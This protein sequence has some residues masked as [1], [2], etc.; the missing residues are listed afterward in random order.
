ME[1][2]LN[3][4]TMTKFN[5]YRIETEGE[6]EWIYAKG[7]LLS[8]L[9]WYID[10]FGLLLN[11]I[12][13]ITLLPQEEWKNQKIR[14]ENPDGGEDIIQTFEDYCKNMK[15]NELISSTGWD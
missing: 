15:Y 11:D 12:D 5:I 3:R 7:D 2:H 8:V 4:L 6:I 1:K 14:I 9:K 10:E 13:S